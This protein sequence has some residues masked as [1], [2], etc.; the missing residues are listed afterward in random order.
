MLDLQIGFTYKLI[1]VS[2][3]PV[4]E[5]LLCY[6]LLI[7]TTG[8]QTVWSSKMINMTNTYSMVVK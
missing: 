6:L 1:R 7:H 8:T 3:V 5:S 2:L 4:L